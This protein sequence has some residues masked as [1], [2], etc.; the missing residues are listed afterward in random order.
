MMKNSRKLLLFFHI[1]LRDSLFQSPFSAR[2]EDI[3]RMDMNY[4]SI[5]GLPPFSVPPLSG[6]EGY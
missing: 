3:D 6:I 2:Y 5:K 4:I 1:Q